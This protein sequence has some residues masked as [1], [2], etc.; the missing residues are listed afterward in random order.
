MPKRMNKRSVNNEFVDSLDSEKEENE[1][2]APLEA[3][4]IIENPDKTIFYIKDENVCRIWFIQEQV[5]NSGYGA[6]AA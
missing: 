1:F 5:A 2:S 6:V 4:R 3:V